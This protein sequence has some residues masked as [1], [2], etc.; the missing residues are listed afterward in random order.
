MNGSAF[1]LL[2]V[3]LAEYSMF[4][5]S[6][7]VTFNGFKADGT[8]VSTSFS[9]DGAI[10]GT[11][12]AADFQTFFFGCDFTD[13]IRVEVPTQGYSLDNLV[14]MVPE[15]SARSLWLLCCMG[16]ALLTIFRRPQ[17]TLKNRASQVSR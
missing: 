10:D 16:A 1:S 8:A 12:P 2:S 7:T 15:P 3:D 14:V 17:S 13:L 5:A 9:L 11:G 6:P 4:F